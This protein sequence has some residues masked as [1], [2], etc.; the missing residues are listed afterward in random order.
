MRLELG[1]DK[2]CLKCPFGLV[3]RLLTP[4]PVPVL[5]CSC[6][7]E[8]AAVRT[9]WVVLGSRP[10]VSDYFVLVLL[11][12]TLILFSNSCPHMLLLQNDS[13]NHCSHKMRLECSRRS[14]SRWF[15]LVPPQVHS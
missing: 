12:P 11:Q 4:F 8:T 13:H 14:I 10:R 5:I 6:L 9:M 3:L 1:Q 7:R 2:V 15:C